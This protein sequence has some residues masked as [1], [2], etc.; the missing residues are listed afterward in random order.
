MNESEE[1]TGERFHARRG[2]SARPFKIHQNMEVV[3]EFLISM[4]I[5]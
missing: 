5:E 2:N 1:T 3:R 4:E